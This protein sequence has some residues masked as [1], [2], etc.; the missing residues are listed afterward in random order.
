M[1][2]GGFAIGFKTSG[3]CFGMPTDSQNTCVSSAV[4]MDNIRETQE[5]TKSKFRLTHTF[6]QTSHALCKSKSRPIW[7]PPPNPSC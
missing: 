5:K 3:V 6:H 7:L 1:A 2:V 4:S